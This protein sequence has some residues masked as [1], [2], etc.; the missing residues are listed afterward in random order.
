MNMKSSAGPAADQGLGSWV[1]SDGEMTAFKAVFAGEWVGYEAD[2]RPDGSMVHD[3]TG[4]C[5]MGR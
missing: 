5:G 4:A 1:Q 2:F 3:A